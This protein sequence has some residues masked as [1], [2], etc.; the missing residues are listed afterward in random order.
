MRRRPRLGT[1]ALLLPLIVFVVFGMARV[2]APVSALGLVFD[3]PAG[4]AVAALA[5]V[6]LANVLL[7]VKPVEL[8]A[9]RV[10]AGPTREPEP[11]ERARLAP[12]LE[13]VGDRAGLRPD[14]L[15]VRIQPITGVNASAGASHL[16]FI[17]QGALAL[18]DEALEAVIA[19]ELGHHRALHPLATAIVWGLSLP[20]AALNAVF[21]ILRGLAGRFR[22]LVLLVVIWQVSVMWLF[23]I[24]ELLSAW[25]ARR[26]EFEADAAAARWGYGMTLGLLY[27]EIAQH[28]LAPGTLLGRL[29]ADHPPTAERVRALGHAVAA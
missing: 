18:P 28:E 5:F 22:P 9:A 7:F 27:V 16:L 10:L 21:R 14:W 12:L 24:G 6:L 15:I 17:T 8:A 3:E 23:W 25:A 11:D 4:F 19:H 1:L 20:G 26:T 29:R 2:A 13:R